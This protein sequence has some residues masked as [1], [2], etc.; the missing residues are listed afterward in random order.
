MALLMKT[1]FTA[2]I[3][4]QEIAM[5]HEKFSP[6]FSPIL[7][8]ILFKSGLQ[9]MTS[10]IIFIINLLIK[11]PLFCDVKGLCNHTVIVVKPVCDNHMKQTT[12]LVNFEAHLTSTFFNIIAKV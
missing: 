8:I 12:L 5:C 7:P 1:L 4:R 11:I 6:N 2:E 9:N 10:A 3:P